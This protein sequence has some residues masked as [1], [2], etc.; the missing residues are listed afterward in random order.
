VFLCRSVDNE[1]EHEGKKRFVNFNPKIHHRRSIR[2]KGYDY[3]QPGAYF[4]TIC[5]YDREC[6][7]G[8]VA[9]EKMI[10]N[11]FGMI[12]ERQ[13]RQI[14]RLFPNA[15][16]DE[17]M[18]MPNHLHGVV[19]IHENGVVGAKH[20]GPHIG[21]ASISV[22][23]DASP[24]Q[25]Q[26]THKKYPIFPHGTVA[27]SFPAMI[28]NFLSITTR[29]INRIRKTPGEKLWQRNYF[30][31]IIRNEK[32]LNRIREYIRNNP[33]KWTEDRDNPF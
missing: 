26:P 29:K 20:P 31:H 1:G 9:E 2:L 18:M 32:K 16:L 8:N 28:Q 4:V 23:G 27:G 5:T 14:P 6:L 13:W 30:E 17:F 25:P 11:E 12:V 24:L 3:T 7:F 19:M 15:L 21:N 22:T 33:A 10:L